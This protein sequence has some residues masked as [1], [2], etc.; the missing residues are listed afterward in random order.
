MSLV[1]VGCGTSPECQL[2]PLSFSSR[3][4]P[5]RSWDEHQ[6]W[7]VRPTLA[8]HLHPAPN[9]PLPTF[10]LTRHLHLVT[11]VLTLALTLTSRRAR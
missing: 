6:A 3:R 5:E 7:Q 11:F 2:S 4:C 10:V 8:H 1:H 9:S